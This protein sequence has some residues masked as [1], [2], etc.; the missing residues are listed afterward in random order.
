MAPLA[1]DE[2]SR[3]ARAAIAYWGGEHEDLAE[4]TGIKLSTLRRIV[5]RTNPRGAN[6]DELERIAQACGVPRRFMLNGFDPD[7]ESLETRIERIEWKLGLV[8]RPAATDSDL[9]SVLEP[10]D[11][12]SQRGRGSVRPAGTDVG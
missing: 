7:G 10:S 9:A 1:V 8:T 12:P 6:P 3:R 4:A 2:A 5:S 11:Q